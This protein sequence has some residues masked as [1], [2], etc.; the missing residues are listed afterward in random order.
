MIRRF[1]EDIDITYDIWAFAPDFAGD[2]ED[3]LP[4][5]RSQEQRWTRAIRARLVEWTREHGLPVIQE[6][7]TRSGCDAKVR[8]DA[9]RIYIGYT[10]LFESDGF[11]KPEVKL[12]FGARSTGEPRKWRPVVCDASL[13]LPDLAF[14]AASPSVMVAEWPATIT[15][16]GHSN[17]RRPGRAY[18]LGKG[19]RHARIL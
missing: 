14:P 2:D 4:P 9:D 15:L 12:E 7:L 3:P 11:V 13:H 17:C 18:V 16:A 6:G 10:P 19:Y 5:T 1:S 8:A